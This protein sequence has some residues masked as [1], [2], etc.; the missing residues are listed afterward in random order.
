VHGPH[1]IEIGVAVLFI[2]LVAMLLIIDRAS[3]G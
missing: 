1:D 2:G 3:R